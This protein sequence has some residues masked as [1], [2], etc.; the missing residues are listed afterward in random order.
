MGDNSGLGYIMRA[1]AYEKIGRKD[2]ADADN[3]KF[4]ELMDKPKQ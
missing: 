2:L 4:R 1:T 3:K